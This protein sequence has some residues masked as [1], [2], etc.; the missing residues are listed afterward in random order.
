MKSPKRKVW[1]AC[2]FDRQ[3]LEKKAYIELRD[4][5]ADRKWRLN[6]LYWIVDKKGEAIPFRLNK[7]QK[8]LLE[9]LHTLNIILKAR[10]LGFSTFIEIFL[11]DMCIFNS[12]IS[13]GIIDES[14]PDAK[15]KLQK[16]KFAY[17]RLGF[18]PAGEETQLSQEI[19]KHVRIIKDNEQELRF[20]NGSNITADTTF[21]GSTLQVLHVTEYA[22]ICQKFPD[23]AREI[24]TGALNAIAKGQIVFIE[25][26]SKSN[27]GH[28]YKLCQSAEK[29]QLTNI[30]LTELDYKFHFFPW[31]EEKEYS[32][33]PPE[34]WKCS[35]EM[36]AYFSKL[37]EEINEPISR[38]QQF[39]YIKTKETQGELMKQE[40]PSTSKE[41]FEASLE[42][43]YYKSI[44]VDLAAKDRICEFELKVG[45]EVDT[46]WDLG[47]SDFTSIIFVQNLGREI[48]IVDFIEG[49]NEDWKIYI[50][51]MKK[52]PY[53]FG[54]I[55][56][57]HD[58][59]RKVLESD[60][61]I[62]DRMSGYFPGKVRI[63][64]RHNVIDGINEVRSLL[65]NCWFKKSTTEL[66]VHHLENYRKKWNAMLGRYTDPAHDEHS[67]AAD[68]FRGL[69][70]SYRVPEANLTARKKVK[71][72]RRIVNPLTGF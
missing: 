36:T 45:I 33:E 32:L 25:S 66:L 1:N 51:E 43:K 18:N 31:W 16:C 26:T 63:V 71:R 49:A 28:F 42:D 17:N 56:L 67:H 55:Y 52:K 48:L 34:T 69:A 72:K 22:T 68:A 62:E 50:E 29:L 61:S 2:N 53:L 15:T 11:L 40:Y 7:F 58:A 5:L 41:A 14:L 54:R 64:E 37:S 65:P 24:R 27:E 70:M 57:P 46:Y 35:Q 59:K 4:R 38:Q 39:W 12:N 19:K 20:S 13:A 23:K 47:R 9:D 30:P 8:K 44:M 6:N 60:K 21:R 3:L 10:Q